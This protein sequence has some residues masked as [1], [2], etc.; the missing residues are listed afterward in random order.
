MQPTIAGTV[1]SQRRKL[2]LGPTYMKS[3]DFSNPQPRYMQLC[4]L[5]P[6]P[7]LGW[8]AYKQRQRA[9]YGAPNNNNLSVPLASALALF[10]FVSF[11]QQQH[12]WTL[13]DG[14]HSILSSR[15]G[16]WVLFM[17]ECPSLSALKANTMPKMEE[18]MSAFYWTPRPPALSR[19]APFLRGGK[20][21]R[22]V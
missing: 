2:H 6:H 5:Q 15:L 9:C 16:G 1:V 3:A 19:C 13:H 12:H 4:C 7:S 11:A 18:N 8:T 20:R 21:V 17:P 14:F 10:C 22:S